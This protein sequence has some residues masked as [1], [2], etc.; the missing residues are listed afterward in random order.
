MPL[1][2]SVLADGALSPDGTR[3]AGKFGIGGTQVIGIRNLFD[4]TEKPVQLAVPDQTEADWVHWVGND[5]VLV[6]L[7]A[8]VP[9]G[10][11]DRGYVTRLIA[12]ER[13]TGKV[14]RIL[15]NLEGQN[16]SDVLWTARDGAPEIL[17]SA[18]HSMY[19]DEGFFPTVHR[20]NLAT[21]RGREVQSARDGV[22]DWQ[23]DGNGVVRSGVSYTK[24]GRL[25][26]LVYRGADPDQPLRTID[27]ANSKAHEALLDPLLFE[28]G[29]DN[30]IATFTS[31]EG[32]DQLF[33]VNMLTQQTGRMLFEAP[34]GTEIDHVVMSQD[35]SAVL[36]VATSDAPS[37]V[38]WLDPDMAEI[39]AAFDKSVAKQGVTVEISSLSADRSAMLVTLARPDSPGALYYFSVANG[40]MQ[41][42][43]VFND[44]LKQ[45]PVSPVKTVR[46]KARDGLEIE[47]VMTVPKGR[48]AHDLPVVMLPHGGPWAQDVASWDYLAQYI[49]SRGYLVIQPNFRGSTGYGTAFRRKG[50]GQMGLAM[51]DDI[52]DGL[53]WAAAQGLA[54]PKRACIVGASYGGYA[55]MWGLAKDPGLYRCGVSISGVASLRREVNDFGGFYMQGKFSD[56]W[57]EMTPD[58]A[59]VSRSTRW[60]GSPRRSVD[61]WSQGCDRGGGPVRCHGQPD[62]RGGQDGGLC[63]PAQGGPLFHPPGRPQ[64]D[65]RCDRRLAGQV[66]PVVTAVIRPWRGGLRPAA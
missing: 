38:H 12:I 63:Q 8:L 41:R 35:R 65:A 31:D 19:L 3:I 49:A 55:T 24:S 44:Q 37:R 64:G 53:A 34:A 26:Q 60:T 23:A 42:I 33:E 45:V 40:T 17:V 50:E 7:R 14:T 46:Y 36:G 2:R 13:A 51:Q 54:D 10:Q 56:D 16:A 58:F 47:A 5:Y 61:P 29:T 43:A 39:Q 57:K 18:Q 21:G 11:G 9:L 15:W 52:S 20:I 22:M 6:K 1:P 48:E 27:K 4:T 25:A 28:P 32:R 59:A 66:Q 62:A 30:A